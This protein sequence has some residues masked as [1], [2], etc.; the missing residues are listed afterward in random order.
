MSLKEFS[1]RRNVISHF[2]AC[3][4]IETR[5]R[6]SASAPTFDYSPDSTKGALNR[7]IIVNLTVHES[8]RSHPRVNAK[9]H[10]RDRVSFRSLV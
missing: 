5:K 1:S 10:D 3:L 6:G 8:F 7:I 4:Q 2:F 9:K